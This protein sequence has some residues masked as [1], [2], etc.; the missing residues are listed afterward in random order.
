M[1]PITEISVPP[2]AVLGYRVDGRP[3]YPIAGGA[4]GDPVVEPEPDDEPDETEA[5][6]DAWTPPTREEWEDHQT[7]FRAASG[8]AAARRKYLKQHG[9]DPKTGNKLNP[10]PAPEEEPP[11]RKDGDEPRGLSPAEVKRQID[12]ATTEAELRGLRKTK[13]LVTG[14]NGV[15]ADSGWNG[16]RLNSLMKL[17]DL[18]DV[19]IDDGGEI[20]GLAEQID[21]I[22]REWPEFF[23]RNRST[24]ANSNAG[25]GQNGAPA[26]KVDT[27]DKKTPEPEPKNWAEALARRAQRG[28]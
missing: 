14:V 17:I 15:L 11:A 16:Q 18:D 5:P 7:K 4:E 9:I 28:A 20:S 12:K 24:T 13:A 23:K 21:D 26:A 8:E 22:K 27:A 19:E 2:T 10:D 25:S 3:I 6:A 1:A